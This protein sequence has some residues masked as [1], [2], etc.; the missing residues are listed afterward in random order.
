MC[1]ITNTRAK[2]SLGCVLKVIIGTQAPEC[3]IPKI[4]V[5]AKAF[6]VGRSLFTCMELNVIVCA[7]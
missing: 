2:V 7:K 4:H 3:Q 5:R 1:L 6:V